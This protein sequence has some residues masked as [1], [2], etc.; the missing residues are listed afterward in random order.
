ME[1]DRSRLVHINECI[2]NIQR[3]ALKGLGQFMSTPMVQEAVLWNLQLICAAASEVSE[4]RKRVHPQV[5]WDHTCNMFRELVPDPWEPDLEQ[6]W[7]CVE[8]ELP[9]LERK[10]QTI[11]RLGAERA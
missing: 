8:A 7:R 9:A 10:I 11:L 1:K 2:H 6:V 4:T 3:Y 5:D